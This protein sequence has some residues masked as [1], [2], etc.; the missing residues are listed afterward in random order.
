MSVLSFSAESLRYLSEGVHHSGLTLH[1]Q[2]SP[3]PEQVPF[4]FCWLNVSLCSFLYLHCHRLEF[5]FKL[6][7]SVN[8]CTMFEKPEVVQFF[9]YFFCFLPHILSKSKSQGTRISVPYCLTEQLIPVFSSVAA[10]LTPV[11]LEICCGTGE[12]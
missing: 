6:I 4:S 9:Y 5:A 12:S 2:Q 10:C 8:V 1:G 7:T 11:L 3:T